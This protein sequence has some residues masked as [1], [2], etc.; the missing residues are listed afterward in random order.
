[1]CVQPH[2]LPIGVFSAGSVD[3]GVAG[4]LVH[5]GVAVGL[6]EALRTLA[7]EAILLIHTGAAVPA[8]VR[9]ALINLHITLWAW[10]REDREEREI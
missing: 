7:V 3:A 10:E 1:M 5:L 2:P 6:V 9:R 8:G 4:T